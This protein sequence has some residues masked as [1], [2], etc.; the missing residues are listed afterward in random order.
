[1]EDD[2]PVQRNFLL[3][4]KQAEWL[5]D[6]AFRTRRRQAEI[7]REALSEYQARSEADRTSAAHHGNRALM[8]RFRNGDGVD[9]DVLR[10][11]AG[12]MWSR[13]P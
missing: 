13:E 3:P 1:M 11:A 12:E 5:R 2:R 8:E 7:V 10:D 4:P 9:L 6:Y